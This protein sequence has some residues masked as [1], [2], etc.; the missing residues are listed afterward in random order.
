LKAPFPDKGRF[1]SIILTHCTRKGHTRRCALI[2][3]ILLNLLTYEIDEE[4]G[5]LKKGAP[6]HRQ[7]KT[8]QQVFTPFMPVGD[9]H[10]VPLGI[11]RELESKNH[12][13]LFGRE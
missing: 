6:Q 2:K 11:V 7:T 10:N 12:L 1:S 8:E 3:R 5:R 9:D 13:F 4:F